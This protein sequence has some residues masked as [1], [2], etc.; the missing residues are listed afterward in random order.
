MIYRDANHKILNY[1]PSIFFFSLPI[2]AFSLKQKKDSR[3]KVYRWEEKYGR[4]RKNQTTLLCLGGTVNKN[5][6]LFY[7]SQVKQQQVEQ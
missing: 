5:L 2:T 7:F 6:S 3:K 4:L 1:H